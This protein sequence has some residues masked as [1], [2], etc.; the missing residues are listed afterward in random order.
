MCG[1]EIRQRLVLCRGATSSVWRGNVQ[2][3]EGQ[4]SVCGWATFSVYYGLLRTTANF[5][6]VEII[7]YFELMRWLS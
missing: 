5:L 4:R 6:I 2:C 1:G 3:V 7:V